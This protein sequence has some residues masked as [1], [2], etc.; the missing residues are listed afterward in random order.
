MRAWIGGSVL[1]ALAI[2]FGAV[3]HSQAHQPATTEQHTILTPSEIKWGPPPPVFR[4]D[5]KFSVLYGDPMKTG[6]HYV[7]MLKMPAGYRIMPHWHP[8]DE[9]ITVL[10]GTFAVGMGDTFAE[11][12]K[13][14][15]VGSFASMPAGMHHYA[16]APTEATVQVTGIGPFKLIYVH[17]EDDPSKQRASTTK[18]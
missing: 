18:Y 10:S 8:V 6:A 1:M 4:K 7:V 9:N 2:V 12:A 16:Y 13:P 11:N 17:P 15:P 5:A 14:L 3:A